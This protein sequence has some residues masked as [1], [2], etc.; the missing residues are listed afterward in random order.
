MTNTPHIT[1]RSLPDT[2]PDLSNFPPLLQR[3]YAARGITHAQELDREL[4]K[5]LPFDTLKDIQKASERLG[6]AIATHERILIVGDFDADGATASAV[7]VSCLR[8]MGATQVDFLVPNRFQFGYGL[9]PGLVGIAAEKK[10]QLIITVD[11]GISSFDGVLAAKEH[12]IEVIVT[13]HHLAADTLP[14][15][16][17]II[18]PNQPGC[19]FPSKTIAGVGVIFYTMLALRRHLQD[20]GWFHPEKN[21]APNMAQFLDLVALG[22]IAD[23]VPLDHN[24]R[25]LVTQG[26]RRIRH[27]QCRAGIQA[28]IE[29]SGRSISHL[30]ESDLGYA[31]GPRL[32]AAG[33]LEDMSLGIRC[34]LT[35]DL[36]EARAL[37]Q[38]LDSLNLERRSIEAEMKTQALAHIQKLH[39]QLDK[40]LNT[41]TLCLFDPAW[42]Q[43]V[44][45]VL[46]GRLKD[47]FHCPTIL[48][49]QVSDQE[50]KG[51]AR[52]IPGVHI[53][54]LLV[55][56]DKS[57]PKLISKF[58][59]HAMAAGLSL[60]P[61]NFDLFKQ[62][63]EEAFADLGLQQAHKQL[64][65]DGPLRPEELHLDTALLLET[66]GPWGQAFPEPCFD[67]VF[68]I[69]DQR[70]IGQHHVKFSLRLNP[71]DEPLD[72][73]AFYA[74][75][76]NWPNYRAKKAHVVY[77]LDCN[78]Y[79]GRQRL[80]LLIENCEALDSQ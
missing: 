1:L 38:E 11:N 60:P 30:K 71:F 9:T 75:Q 45:G 43:G 50:L 47:S 19:A 79:Q 5:L 37:A 28:L 15:A 77:K 78:R 67:N 35:T 23:V 6:K 55:N 25:V 62:A 36:A 3:I 58:G 53:R 26:L 41:A 42:H 70:V 33:R 27:E 40:Q 56:I 76:S 12:N 72:A 7:A 52:S 69:L 10:A 68:E 24:N 20:T 63:F 18:N 14:E 57:H 4:S 21:P 64:W 48:F 73:I 46:A 65:S 80:Q 2:L 49:A 61:E 34:L 54:D 59:G 74:V 16:Y 29:I 51:S 17:A 44:I 32:N 66:A 22:T 8:A 13:D 31:I 39:Q